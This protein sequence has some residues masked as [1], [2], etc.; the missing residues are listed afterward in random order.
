MVSLQKK[1][2]ARKVDIMIK[3]IK[4]YVHMLY[5]KRY[6]N[7]KSRVGSFLLEILRAF[8]VQKELLKAFH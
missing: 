5:D 7:E 1:L 8:F 2:Y 6:I 3:A 4:A